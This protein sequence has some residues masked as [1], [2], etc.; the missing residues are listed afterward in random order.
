MTSI[1]KAAFSGCSGLIEI[2]IP[3]VGT[4]KDGKSNKHFGY[5]F[6]ATT[7]NGNSSDVP[8]SLKTVIITGGSSIGGDAFSLCKNLSYISIPKSVSSIGSSAFYRCYS[9]T[10]VSFAEDTQLSYIGSGA[11]RECSSLT[12]ITIPEGVTEI[13]DMAFFRCSNLTKVFIPDSVTRME[14][15]FVGCTS[16]VYNKYDNAYYLGNSENP[17]VALVK[18]ESESSISECVIHEDT[19]VIAGFA[20]RDCRRLLSITIPKGLKSIGDR[21]FLSCY[22][23]VDVCNLSELNIVKGST[24]NGYVGYYAISVHNEP[25]ENSKFSTDENGY[26]FYTDG[27]LVSL[28]GY[29][30]SDT[31]LC[32][33]LGVTEIQAGAFRSCSS[34]TEATI[35]MGVT[36]IGEY[37]FS[38][39]SSLTSL[40][41]PNSVTSID[42]Y[43]FYYSQAL[44]T[45]TF[46]G[47]KDQ[48]N[49]IKK[50]VGWNYWGDYKE[51]KYTIHCTDGDIV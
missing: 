2:T 48:W 37:A 44:T 15:A 45:I 21:A 16:L 17:Y 27:E 20:F 49:A 9:L 28:V 6:G 46:Q 29:D 14:S 24:N 13:G 10:T 19:K 36:S 18:T 40:I 34:F 3:F 50:K 25:I 31:E 32:I 1:E 41:I 30:G 4:T 22:R 47:T 23:L 33:P 12:S 26:I 43:A 38:G 11:F 42:G 51:R 8:A 35:P 5:I 39:C 7:Y